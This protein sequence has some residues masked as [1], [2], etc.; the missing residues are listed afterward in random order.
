M[1]NLK[2]DQ[3]SD[4]IPLLTSEKMLAYL[5]GKLTGSERQDVEQVIEAHEMYKDVLEGFAQIQDTGRLKSEI[6]NLNADLQN[7]YRAQRR[8][9]RIR[10][11]F[12][13]AAVI[14]LIAAPAIYFGAPSQNEKIFAAY[15][16]PYPN[17]TPIVRGDGAADQFQSAM[18]A[19]ER[20]DYQ[21][22]LDLF[23]EIA[24]ADDRYASA[25]FYAALS[26]LALDNARDAIPRLQY[27]LNQG[28]SLY[29]DAV[30]W[31]LA[32]A[33][34][35][36]GNLSEGRDILDKLIAGGSSFENEA[37]ALRKELQK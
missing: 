11:I 24:D 2:K 4:H 30:E 9:L 31:Y 22:A 6:E 14:L 34:I 36:N 33:I 16:E 15:F 21:T 10:R 20:Q 37:R 1:S 25:Q 23:S 17:L 18:L 28:N 12:Y 7:Q 3:A 32:L 19:Y 29:S 5:E 13:A 26:N 27:V 35:R 8:A